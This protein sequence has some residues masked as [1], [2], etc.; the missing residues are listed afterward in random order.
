MDTQMDGHA[1][2]SIDEVP[3]FDETYYSPWRIKIKWYLKSKGAGVWD[4]V[5]VGSIPSKKK[6]KF[7]AQKETNKKNTMTFKT[8]FN[9]LSVSVKESIRQCTFS[10][11][12][13][14]SLEKAYQGKIQDTKDNPI[15]DVKK[16]SVINEGKDPPKYFDCN[17]YKCDDVECSPTNKEEDM[18]TIEEV[19]VESTNNYHIDE[20]EDL[21]K[22][23]DKVIVVL[24]EVSMERR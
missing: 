17:N 9:G 21:L 12:L 10:K 16:N 23:K 15:K 14:L 6:S 20:E 18:D 7:V 11:D 3:L 8:I 13:W 22:L 2:P 24:G 4:T 5:V 1:V 19:C